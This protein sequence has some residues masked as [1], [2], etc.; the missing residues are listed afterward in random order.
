MTWTIDKVTYMVWTKSSNLYHI[1]QAIEVILGESVRR[2]LIAL[3]TLVTIEEKNGFQTKMH[4]HI[5]LPFEGYS[6]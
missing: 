3:K 5:S 6:D 1:G 4:N 2:Q